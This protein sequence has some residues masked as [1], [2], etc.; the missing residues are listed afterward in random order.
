MNA[1]PTPSDA[2]PRL[3]LRDFLVA[4]AVLAG[5]W[6]LI[7][8]SLW[9][10]SPT[11]DELVHATGG[12]TYWRWNDYRINPEAGN[13]PQRVAG[14]PLA[15]APVDPPRRDSE[16]WRLS[17]EWAV[18]DSWFYRQGNS[19]ESMLRGGRAACAL[20]AVALG[21]A[22]W[23]A[24]ARL[25]GRTGGMIALLLYALNP[26]ILANGALMTSDAAAALGLLGAALALWAVLGQLSAARVGLAGLAVGALLVCKM[27][28][29]LVAPIALVL[30]AA[31]GACGG[32]LAASAGRWR[33]EI[34]SRWVQAAAVT[35]GFAAVALVAAAVVWAAYG[36][37]YSAFSATR[38][39]PGQ[40]DPSWEQVLGTSRSAGPQQ[41]FDAARRYHV[42]PEGFLYGC[43]YAW[44]FSRWRDAFWNGEHSLQGWRLFFPYTFLVKTPIALLALM[45]LAGLA[46]AR[47]WAA[48]RGREGTTS[49]AQAGRGIYATLPLWTLIAIAGAAASFGHLDIGHRHILA[50]YPPLFTLC[51]TALAPGWGGAPGE[52]FP[53]SRWIRRSTICLLGILALETAWSFPDYIAYFNGFVRPATAYRHLVD[54]SLDWGQ[55]L[56]AVRQYIEAHPG[57]GPFSLSYF[58]SASPAAYGVRASVTNCASPS[59]EPAGS[60][61]VMTTD[62]EPDRLKAGM[63][64]FLRSHPEYEKAGTAVV[65]TTGLV[66]V[67]WLKRAADLRLVPGTYLV[68]ATVLQQMEY[69]LKA[70]WGPWNRRFEARYQTLRSEMI[71]LMGDDPGARAAALGRGSTQDWWN[72]L[73]DV[74]EFDALRFSRLAAYLRH[75]GPDVQLH[76]SILVFRLDGSDLARALDGPP[77]ELGRDMPEELVASGLLQ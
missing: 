7:W 40:F 77:A 59:E 69:S 30:G 48:V 44:K 35:A 29:A 46:T 39:G 54:S 41:V 10:K 52:A 24:A 32:P 38:G 27:S 42:L 9:N 13:L 34:R 68:S 20:I 16:A 21:F 70:P 64:E 18:A 26:T 61:P 67:I 74:G 57:Q 63:D 15:L 76:G 2:S 71:P 56:P 62:F 17:R 3:G 14:L 49:M 72:L 51:G 1:G 73:R 50:V 45:G 33:R 6:L 58:G 11:Y 36:F 47:R 37:R 28:G 5:F 43:A 55:D 53:G 23:L 66:R 31:R 4:G 75:R 60:L 19:F 65:N 22:V 8:G 25:S 12:F